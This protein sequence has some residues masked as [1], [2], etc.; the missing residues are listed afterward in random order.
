MKGAKCSKVC[1]QIQLSET[2]NQSSTANISNLDIVKKK[3][4]EHECTKNQIYKDL[5]RIERCLV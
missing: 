1:R 3:N 5:N 2:N 4:T